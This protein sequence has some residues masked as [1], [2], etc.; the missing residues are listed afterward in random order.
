[1]SKRS[2]TLSM[3]QLIIYRLIFI[4]LERRRVIEKKESKI[5]H[6]G[7]VT[8]LRKGVRN[9]PVPNRTLFYFGKR[10]IHPVEGLLT[11]EW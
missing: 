6:F 10:E 11:D 9:E 4:Y 3:K 1:M 7:R 8:H 2:I 5:F